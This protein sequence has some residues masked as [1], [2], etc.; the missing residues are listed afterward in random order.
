MSTDFASLLSKNIEDVEAPKP[1]PVGEYRLRVEGTEET[2]SKV[3]GTPGM[4]V[5][6]LVTAADSSIDKEELG[7]AVGNKKLRTTFWLAEA[8]MFMLGDFLKA[9]GVESG[10][11]AQGLLNAVGKEVYASV[12]QKPADNGRL[13]NEI[14]SFRS[15]A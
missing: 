1:V 9:C 8:A 4:I 2:N 7:N 11:F 5:H 15:V 6:F 3:K 14:T 13:Y 10:S 12:T